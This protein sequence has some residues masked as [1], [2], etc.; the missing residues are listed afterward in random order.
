MFNVS[1]LHIE[2]AEFIF[3]EMASCVVL[4]SV[5]EELAIL[6]FHQ[7]IIACLKEGVIRIDA[8][9]SISIKIKKGIAGMR[10]NK[11]TVL[12]SL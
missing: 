4:P 5:E 9:N 3:E 12:V 8:Q 10:G 6:D 7:S 1:V 2:K 11:L